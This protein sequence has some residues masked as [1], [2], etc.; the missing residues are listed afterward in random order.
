MGSVPMSRVD[1]D[2]GRVGKTNVFLVVPNFPVSGG[3]TLVGLEL[4]LIDNFENPPWVG[5][6]W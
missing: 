1:L 4:V 5:L 3:F 2:S 6:V